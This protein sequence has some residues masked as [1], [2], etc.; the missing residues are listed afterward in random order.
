VILFRY[1]IREHILPF[2]Y[3]L[4]IIIFILSMQFVVQNLAN[5]MSKGL[6]PGVVFELYLINIAWVMALAIPMSILVATLMAFGQMSGNNEIMA[7]KASG[8]N[9]TFLI[10]PVFAA[11]CVFMVLTIYFNNDILPDA[12]HHAANLLTDI[13]RKKPAALIEPG[14]LITSF[15]NYA[16]FAKKV[17]AN[18]GGLKDVKIFSQVPGEDPS[19]TVA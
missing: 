6:G 12:N 11:A 5:I 4:G 18:T 7:I 1:I 14:V 17:N 9:L 19:T 16:L 3:S 8:H 13:S 15:E 10:A 2:L